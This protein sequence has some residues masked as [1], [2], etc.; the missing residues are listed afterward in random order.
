MVK[1]VPT[2]HLDNNYTF[3]LHQ[4]SDFGMT[5]CERQTLDS[6]LLQPPAVNKSYAE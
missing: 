1:S 5:M 3:S 2:C 6:N 4:Q